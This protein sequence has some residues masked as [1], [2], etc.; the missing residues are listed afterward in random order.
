MERKVLS[1]IPAQPGWVARFRLDNGTFCENQVAIWAVVVDDDGQRVTGFS[2]TDGC[3]FMSPDDTV[4]NF[5]GW[6]MATPNV[7]LSSAACHEKE[8]E[9]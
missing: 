4:S 1:I 8:L 9:G 3:G 7:A 2:E 5:E 6:V